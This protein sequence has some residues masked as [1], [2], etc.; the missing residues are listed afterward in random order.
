MKI[1]KAYK[2]SFILWHDDEIWFLPDQIL[3]EDKIKTGICFTFRKIE[4]FN[5]CNLHNPSLWEKHKIL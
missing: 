4:Y 5:A 1:K 3:S 2:N